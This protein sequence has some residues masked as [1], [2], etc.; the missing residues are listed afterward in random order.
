MNSS[1]TAR[2]LRRLPAAAA[3]L[4][5]GVALLAGCGNPTD[6]DPPTSTASSSLSTTTSTPNSTAPPRVNDVSP[7]TYANPRSPDSYLWAYA[8]DPVR[9]CAIYPVAAATYV[10][11][12]VPF[13][14]GTPPV[15]TDTGPRSPNA[16]QI[17]EHGVANTTFEPLSPTTAPVL[18][19]NSRIT[20]GDITCT[21]LPSNGIDCTTP[22][23]HFR[24][25]DGRLTSSPPDTTPPPSA[26]RPPM[27]HY[28]EPTTP[29]PAGTACGAATRRTVVEV[30]SGSIS[31]VEALRVIDHYRALPPGDF[32]NANI[33][34]FDG[35]SCASPTAA[36]ALE[37]GYSTICSKDDVELVVLSR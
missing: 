34:Q 18:P 31:C 9:E 29:V 8:T 26:D 4:A 37:Q 35:W 19:A 16:I 22:R 3:A 6:S 15:V 7:A 28:T 17:T 23:G 27:D 1:D 5:A 33:R 11:C 36:R 24:F 20:V 12:S 2:S 32:G 21:A 25:D 14:A 13:P 30:R 10:T